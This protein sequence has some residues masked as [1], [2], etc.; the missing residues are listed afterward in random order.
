M[1]LQ[2]A[3]ALRAE[4][5]AGETP[6]TA[7]AA[8][9][10]WREELRAFDSA[11]APLSTTS[12]RKAAEKIPPSPASEAA[13]AELQKKREKVLED[14]HA[15]EQNLAVLRERV[16]ARLQGLPPLAEIEENIA[17][18][19]AEVNSLENARQALELARDYIAHAAQKLHHDFAPRLNEFL[20][21][22]LEKLTGGRYV[23][24]M[25]D[26]TD[27][28]VRLQGPAVPAPV[29]LTKLSLGTIEQVYL[30]LRAAVM[31]IFAESGESIPL[32]LDDPLI[33]ADA[34][35]MANALQ[36][37]DVLAESHQ[38]FYFTKDPLVFEHFHGQP[39]HCAI[40][41]LEGK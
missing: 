16:E 38:I 9:A 20:G 40:I 39:E 4:I 13:R 32:L 12:G 27:F 3:E 14:I 2:Q 21:R 19:E 31:E 22:H 30:L 26:P 8:I 33:H 15:R 10:R 28:S 18:V 34:R 7:A 24:A 6:E 17:L 37:I 23:E 5:L 29:A 36:I 35:R 25:V 1:Q 41:A 11:A